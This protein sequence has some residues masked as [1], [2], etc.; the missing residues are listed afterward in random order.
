[1]LVLIN[2]QFHLNLELF[3]NTCVLCM[4]TAHFCTESKIFIDCLYHKAGRGPNRELGFFL[5]CLLKSKFKGLGINLFQY[6]ES[7]RRYLFRERED[8]SWQVRQECL[9][10]L[11]GFQDEITCQFKNVYQSLSA[12]FPCHNSNLMMCSTSHKTTWNA[13]NKLRNPERLINYSQTVENSYSIKRWSSLNS[14]AVRANN[15]QFSINKIQ[16]QSIDK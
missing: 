10:C 8:L 4:A 14:N 16:T 5:G 7:F 1:M 15:D 2:S 3:A 11:R 6:L 12:H 13:E 9:E